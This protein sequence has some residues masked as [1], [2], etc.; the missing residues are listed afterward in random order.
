MIT[1]VFVLKIT[2]FLVIVNVWVFRFKKSTPYRGGQA[3]TMTEEFT[4]YNLPAFMLYLVGVLKM[5]AA[6]T[7]LLSLF[8]ENELT[9]LLVEYSL[10]TMCLL[11]VGAILMHIKIS[12]PLMKSLPAFL[13]LVISLAILFLS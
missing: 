7:L 6:S 9:P 13:M 8:I 5:L 3:T 1:L 11:M 12:D 4:S 10:Y 2:L